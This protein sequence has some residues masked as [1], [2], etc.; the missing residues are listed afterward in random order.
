MVELDYLIIYT[1]QAIPAYSHKFNPEFHISDDF[2]LSAFLTSLK[3]YADLGEEGT[4]P[5]DME[6]DGRA[7]KVQYSKELQLS[8]IDLETT[9][10]LF[11]EAK[12]V[13]LTI[14]VG[15]KQN[16]RMSIAK[17]FEVSQMMV[18]LENYMQNYAGVDWKSVDQ[19]VLEEIDDHILSDVIHKYMESHTA[20]DEC[21]LGDKCP[22]R[23]SPD[24][25]NEERKSFMGKI[26]TRFGR[27]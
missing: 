19:S 23:L 3:L 12:K 22:F 20:D 4:Q 14:G 11:Y 13:A 17:M 16:N 5:S 21:Y 8:M 6:L 26:K 10:L 18:D 15:V 7:I 9:L 2:L 24:E 1:D 25:L 27:K